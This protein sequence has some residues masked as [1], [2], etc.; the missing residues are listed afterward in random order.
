MDKI[1]NL[2]TQ[3]SKIKSQKSKILER[4][5]KIKGQVE[6]IEGMLKKDRSCLEV[7]QQLNAVRQAVAKVQ[8]IMLAQELCKNKSLSKTQTAENLVEKLLKNL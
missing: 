5:G 8:T 7:V 2:K 6:G 3:N 1:S 4:M